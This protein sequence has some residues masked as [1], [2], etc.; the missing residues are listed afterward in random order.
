MKKHEKVELF[1]NL[2]KVEKDIFNEVWAE[3]SALLKKGVT[4]QKIQVHENF[5][6]RLVEALTHYFSL[7]LQLPMFSEEKSVLITGETYE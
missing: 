1:A 3:Y 5:S 7:E 4:P 6:L 2:T